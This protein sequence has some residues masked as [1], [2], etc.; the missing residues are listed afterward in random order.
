MFC[1]IGICTS[2][3]LYAIILV[4][5]YLHHSTQFG[6]MGWSSVSVQGHVGLGQNHCT[7]SEIGACMESCH[8]W[9]SVV[10]WTNLLG[11]AFKVSYWLGS[12]VGCGCGQVGPLLGLCNPLWSG[13][14][15]GCSHLQSGDTG[16][17]LQLGRAAGCASHCS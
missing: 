6:I 10:G 9:G 13:E 11:S 12:L 8:G 4:G 1:C 7:H 5:K 2:P 16:L 3:R 17:I 15:A 14:V